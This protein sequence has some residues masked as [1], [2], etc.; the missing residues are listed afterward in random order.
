MGTYPDLL[1]API[2]VK[3]DAEVHAL[4]RCQMILTEAKKRAS[5]EFEEILEKSGVT[6]DKIRAYEKDHPELRRA[7]YRVP[8]KG[9]PGTASNYLL[10]LA[11]RL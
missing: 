6:V 1:Y 3:G 4:S 5:Q 11:D 10:H 2:E 7:T 9:V 8:H